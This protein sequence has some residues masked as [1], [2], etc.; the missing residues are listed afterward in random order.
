M[1]KVF[2]VD[3]AEPSRL[4]NPIRFLNTFG[5]PHGRWLAD[6]PATLWV[7]MMLRQP[8]LTARARKQIEAIATK[9]VTGDGSKGVIRIPGLRYDDS[10]RWLAN[11]IDQSW[12]FD[13]IVSEDETDDQDV[14]SLDDCRDWRT[15]PAISVNRAADAYCKA[16]LPALR[17]S[18]E[19]RFVDPYFSVVDIDRGNQVP[20]ERY[21]N[22]FEQLFSELQRTTTKRPGIEIHTSKKNE[23]PPLSQFENDCEQYFAPRLPNGWHVT[24][25]RWKQIWGRERLH[26]RYV[27]TN[28]GGIGIQGGLDEAKDGHQHTTSLNL[29]GKEEWIQKWHDYDY[30]QQPSGSH[31]FRLVDTLKVTSTTT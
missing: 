4:H 29:M 21:L 20:S 11:A 5:M 3:P 6:Y 9:L 2:A 18:R 13:E 25:V 22:V 10:D 7:D 19:I 15:E 17:H 23:E 30:R 1:I 8:R 12:A 28:M 24:I 27:L 14:L 31:S 16:L 26:D